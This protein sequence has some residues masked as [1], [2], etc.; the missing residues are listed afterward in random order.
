MNPS[1]GSRE[2]VLVL[3]FGAQ[4]NQLITRKIRE[5]KVYSELVP[6]DMPASEIAALGPKGL[7][8]SGGPASVYDEGAPRCDP[9]IFDL[10]IPV[11]GICY[12][13]QLTAFM[14]GGKV[15]QGAEREYGPA[16][17]QV[18][19][20]DLLFQDFPEQ[21]DCWMSHGDLV[22][23]APEGFEI[24]AKT[25]S[26]PIAAMGNASRQLYGVQFHPEVVH[27]PLGLEVLRHFLEG[28]CGC[29]RDWTAEHFVELA[30][31]R[32]REQVGEGR[33]LTAVSGGVDSLVTAALIDKAIGE[34]QTCVFVDHGLLR[35]NEGDQVERVFREHFRSELIRVD[36]V[37][38]FL[39]KLAGVTEPERKRLIIGEEFIRVFEEE[40]AKLGH[41]DFLGQGTIY[42][43]VIESGGGKAETIKS[44]H[45]VGGLP[46]DM[47]FSLVEPLR[48]LFK[49]E[50]R[51]VGE[52]A[53]LPSDMIWRHPFPGPGLAIRIIGEVTEERLNILREADAII[54]G[55]IKQAGLYRQLWQ[56]F[57]VL[58]AIQS[59]GVMGDARTYAYPI[60][61]RAV[62][63]Q[64]A[65]T[66]DFAKL[67]WELLA[68][69][70]SRIVNEVAGVNR[71]VYDVTPKPPATIEW[72]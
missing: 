23:Q 27:T 38:R 43:D 39:T 22:E 10:G 58:P 29:A 37:Y 49:D 28:A 35:K 63:S 71:V 9:A 34:R 60:V 25:A 53:G 45:N 24:L 6:G 47:Q 64:D 41:F 2:T 30:V 72:E 61:L 36:A 62:E 57:G 5:L 1:T 70:S 59:V 52:R 67:P 16:L 18:V 13:M 26:T 50:V 4:Y 17:A 3:D 56:V 54:V 44:H 21:F 48:E 68:R 32:I 12:G 46:E 20:Q 66:A 55:E 11:L 65:M 69:I 14:L 40:A 51:R 33:V 19:S 31:R 15:S 42:P 7:I 8:L